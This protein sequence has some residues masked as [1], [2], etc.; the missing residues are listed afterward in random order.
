MRKLAFATII[1][2][3][4]LILSCSALHPADNS[5][6][7]FD[8]YGCAVGKSVPGRK[9]VQFIFTA[10][11]AFEGGQ[12]ALDLLKER[13]LK[14]SFF[15]TGN[16]MRDSANH[17]VIKRA[18]AD[19][20]YVGPHGDRHI[21]LADW[22]K[23]RNT[24]ASPDSALADMETAYRHLAEFGISRDN[25]LYLVPSYEWYNN[26]HINAFKSVGLFPV[27]LSPGIETYRDYTTTDL[28]YYTPSDEIWNQFLERESTHGVDGA[29]ILIHLGTDSTRTDKFYRYL[30]AML[31]TLTAR[32]YSIVRF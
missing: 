25:A 31:D 6:W 32:G 13:D 26:Q 16:F 18:I 2:L 22:N 24:L 12:Y 8:S 21:L 9:T 14:A 15:F 5:V 3:F 30:P 27:N 17:P 20:H 28:P 4:T 7:T 10:D 19:G 23:E 29:I 1:T 11:S